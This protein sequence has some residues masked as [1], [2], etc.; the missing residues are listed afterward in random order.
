MILLLIIE[1]YLPF[2]VRITFLFFLNDTHLIY[3]LEGEAAAPTESPEGESPPESPTTAP[4][5][6]GDESPTETDATAAEAAD[7]PT[8]G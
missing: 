4:E 3:A 1:K 7:A 2:S 8:E 6:P 5:T